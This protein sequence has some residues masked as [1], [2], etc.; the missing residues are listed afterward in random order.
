LVFKLNNFAYDSVVGFVSGTS[1]AA[2]HFFG[3][4][5]YFDKYNIA[6]IKGGAIADIIVGLFAVAASQ[7]VG[8]WVKTILLLVG[9]ALM[10]IGVAHAAGWTTTITVPA[11]TARYRAPPVRTPVPAVKIF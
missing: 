3:F 8:G 9:G 7:M 4:A 2:L 1:G 11:A 6:G 10:G 5:P